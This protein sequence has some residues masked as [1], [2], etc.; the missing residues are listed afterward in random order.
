MDLID[1]EER[2]VIGGGVCFRRFDKTKMKKD[3]SDEG[4]SHVNDLISIANHH[5]VG[6]SSSIQQ[7]CCALYPKSLRLL[8]LSMS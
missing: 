1:L 6:I 7:P 5:R 4:P 8:V 2:A 3:P